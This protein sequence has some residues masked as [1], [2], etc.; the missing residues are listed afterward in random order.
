MYDCTIY[1]VAGDRQKYRHRRLNPSQ[2]IN[3]TEYHNVLIIYE[4]LNN[5]HFKLMTYGYSLIIFMCSH[6]S[7]IRQVE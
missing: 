2:Q 1:I 7:P 3:F 5:L 4:P 6:C